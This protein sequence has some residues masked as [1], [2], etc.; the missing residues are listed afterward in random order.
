M[1]TG[2]NKEEVEDHYEQIYLKEGNP[3]YFP[4]IFYFL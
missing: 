3:E 4:V 1:G 2:K